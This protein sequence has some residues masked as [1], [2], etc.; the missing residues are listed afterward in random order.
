[1]VDKET[2]FGHIAEELSLIP[3]GGINSAN[4]VEMATVFSRTATDKTTSRSLVGQII[5]VLMTV[6]M[7]EEY[8]HCVKYK[9]QQK[10][11]SHEHCAKG[12]F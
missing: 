7:E 10:H 2:L 4:L 3:S 6:G 5:H 12:D 8:L 1:M 11:K 9:T